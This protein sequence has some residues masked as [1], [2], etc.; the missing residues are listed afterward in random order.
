MVVSAL[1]LSLQTM[2]WKIPPEKERGKCRPQ[3]SRTATLHWLIVTVVC[4]SCFYVVYGGRV[5][6]IPAT[7]LWLELG[8]LKGSK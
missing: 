8:V 4:L 2:L 1:A 5:N 7:A 3:L 6:P